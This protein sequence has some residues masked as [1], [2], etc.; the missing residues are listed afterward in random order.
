MDTQHVTTCGLSHSPLTGIFLIRSKAYGHPSATADSGSQ[1]PDGDFFDPEK[2]L[3]IAPNGFFVSHSPLTGIFL[4]RR[5]FVQSSDTAKIVGHSPLT[6]IFLIRS[7][8]TDT[9]FGLLTPSQSPDGDFF[10]PEVPPP[11]PA[12]ETP[13]GHSPL[14]GIFLIRSG[15]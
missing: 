14:T 8:R 2:L 5:P 3:G 11:I 13:T 12:T 10:D 1:S 15:Y 6:G 7:A 9:A 4:I